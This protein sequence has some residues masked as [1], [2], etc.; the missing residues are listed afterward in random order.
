MIY[1]INM[2]EENMMQAK[3]TIRVHT[4]CGGRWI[5]IRFRFSKTLDKDTYDH[6]H[7]LLET[8]AN[9]SFE[10]KQARRQQQKSE[11]ALPPRP[12]VIQL[13]LEGCVYI[14]VTKTTRILPKQ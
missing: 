13:Q 3:K 8:E 14:D 1:I 6:Y 11:Q 10:K 7:G 2:K 4:R 5:N 9:A 12:Q